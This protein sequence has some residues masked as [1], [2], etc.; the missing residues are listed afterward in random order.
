M[1]DHASGTEQVLAHAA[2]R[3]QR[4]GL[5]YAGAV[6]PQEAK[7]LADAGVARIVD[8]RTQPEYEQVGHIPGTPLIEWPRNGG[9]QEMQAFLAALQAKYPTSEKLLF[10]CR[11]C[12]RSHYA[13]EL[14]TQAGY[15]SAYNILEGFEGEYGAGKNGWRAGGLPWQTGKE[16]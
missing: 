4:M 6:T 14:A 7:Q 9:P 1:N 2:E 8:V 16:G 12:V 13:A 15:E 10:L 3:G 5:R 11:S